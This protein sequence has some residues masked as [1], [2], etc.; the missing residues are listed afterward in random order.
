MALATRGFI[1]FATAAITSACA[2]SFASP[3]DFLAQGPITEPAGDER[4]GAG[5]ATIDVTGIPSMDGGGSPNN[6]VIFL[7]IGPHNFVNGVGWDVVLQTLVPG[8]RRNDIIMSV[9]NTSGDEFSGFLV[10]P[11]GADTTPGGPT[12]YSSG[13]VLKLANY[14]I[15]SVQALGDG[16]IRLEFGEGRDDAP[17]SADALWLS[18]T[19]SFQTLFS[20]PPVVSPGATGL[21]VLAGLTALKRRRKGLLQSIT[22]VD[23]GRDRCREV[24]NQARLDS[25]GRESS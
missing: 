9:R 13:G 21:F 10:A 17:N 19:V 20:I 23:T 14:N 6:T 8:S 25:I 4:A 12:S 11:G 15:P 3:L 18:G 2:R 5:L 22:A 16:L 1:L 24:R 7:W